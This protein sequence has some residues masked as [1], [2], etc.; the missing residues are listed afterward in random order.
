M[1]IYD[2]PLLIDGGAVTAPRVAFFTTEGT[3]DVEN[4]GV[5]PDVE[6]ELDPKAWRE[7]HDL[8]L[9][10]TVEILMKDLENNPPPAVKRPAF[11]DYS[12]I[13]KP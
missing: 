6:I 11:P 2:Y 4:H 10:K 8:Q 3:W 1:G 9:E 5:Q 7:G 13:S 12:N